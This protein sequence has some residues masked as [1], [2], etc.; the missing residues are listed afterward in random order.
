[1]KINQIKAAS[2]LLLGALCQIAFFA[3]GNED[4]PIGSS[5]IEDNISITVDSAFTI[6]G[7]SVPSKAVQ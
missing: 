1:M 7:E 4:S 2:T 6:T 5:I 3:C